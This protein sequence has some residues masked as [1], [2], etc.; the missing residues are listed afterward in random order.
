MQNG[1]QYRVDLVILAVMLFSM[2]MYAVMGTCGYATYGTQVKSD[3]LMSYPS[4][5]LV[6]ILRIMI[7]FV[8]T[9][10]YPLSINP[11]RRCLL[12]FFK[13]LGRGD[14]QI[15]PPKNQELRKRYH[16]SKAE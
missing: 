13:E 15:L 11:A 4:T 2:L 3:I 16:C 5:S 12:T 1:T 14:T 10:S 6:S 7:S 8:V 9:F